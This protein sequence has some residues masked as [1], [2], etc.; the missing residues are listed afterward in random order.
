MNYYLIGFMGAGKTT[1]GHELATLGLKHLDLDVYIQNQYQKIAAEIIEEE[2][3][4]QFRLYEQKCFFKVSQ[5]DNYIISLGGGTITIP[6]VAEYLQKQ[7]Y[8]IYLEADCPILYKRIQQDINNVRPLADSYVHF[9]SLFDSRKP[10]Y[11][12]L[13]TIKINANQNISDTVAQIIQVI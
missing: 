13:A 2:G 12:K 5:Q 6:E 1:I 8:V 3:I 7:K 9:T 10:L 11:D 4:E